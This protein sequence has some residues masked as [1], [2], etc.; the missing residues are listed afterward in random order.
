M[1]LGL[2]FFALSLFAAA[3]VSAPRVGLVRFEDG[4]VRPLF[5]VSGSFTVG[6]PL[7]RGVDAIAFDGSRGWARTTE[8]ILVLGRDAEVIRREP[9][10]DDTPRPCELAYVDGDELVVRASGR[11]MRLPFA[12]ERL[13]QAGAEYVALS[14]PEGRLLARI[15]DGREAIFAMPEPVQ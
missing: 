3:Q 1:R 9:L 4:T 11:R 5:G 7:L 2:A 15:G 6:E 13:E 12:I 14:G 8:E 10:T